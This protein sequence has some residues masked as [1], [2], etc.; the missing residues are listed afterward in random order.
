MTFE[1]FKWIYQR[2]STLLIIIL[3]IWLFLSA[4]H[5]ADYE[6]KNIRLFFE[7]SFNLF[8]FIIFIFLSLI[9]TAIEVYHSIDDYFSGTKFKKIIKFITNTLYG[10]IFFSIIIFIIKFTF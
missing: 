1:T 8:F 9:H 10:I 3:S 2:S 4:Y 5:L 7:N 6:Y